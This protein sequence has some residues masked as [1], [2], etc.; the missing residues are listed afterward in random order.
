MD[1]T[2]ASDMGF[3]GG[4][5]G[6]RSSGDESVDESYVTTHGWNGGIGKRI[7]DSSADRWV[8]SRVW[9]WAIEAAVHMAGS[10]VIGTNGAMVG[11]LVGAITAA[12]PVLIR[13]PEKYWCTIHV[14]CGNDEIVG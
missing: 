8:N 7:A 4:C 2:P 13:V 10:V 12:V 11:V 5:R 3:H 1:A 9:Q 6:C 14:S